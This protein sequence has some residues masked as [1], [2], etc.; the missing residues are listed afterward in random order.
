M[1]A[2]DTAGAQD[3]I[4]QVRALL[5]RRLS[6]RP[7]DGFAM[8]QMSWVNLALNRKADALRLAQQGTDLNPIEK[9]AP[10]GA[11][12]LTALAEIQARAS[13][14]GEAVKTLGRLLSIPAVRC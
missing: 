2:G 9:D 8:T 11:A 6:D 13:Q 1:L 3:E 10:T 5:E 14:A 4:E 7:D 12:F